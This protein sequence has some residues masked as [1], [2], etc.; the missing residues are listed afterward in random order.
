VARLGGDEFAVLI[1]VPGG[2]PGVGAGVDA[3]AER[4]LDSF[5]RP[6]GDGTNQ[7][8]LQV[9]V[10]VAV[11]GPDGEPDKE[12]LRN[13]DLAMN[14]AR[15]DGAGSL[16]RFTPAVHQRILDRM[17]IEIDLQRALARDELVLYYQPVVE[18]ASGEIKG[19][20]ALIR[21]AHPEKGLV[22]P[23]MFIAVAES[24]GLIVTIG[25]WVLRQACQDLGKWAGPGAPKLRMSVNVSARQLSHPGFEDM[26]VRVLGDSGADPDLITLEITESML[27]HDTAGKADV[28]ER[29]RAMGTRIA[30]D[31]F[32]TGYSSLSS[33]REMPI[34][35]LKIDKSFIDNIASSPEAVSLTQTIIRL[36]NDLGLT[37]IAEGAEKL[38]QVEILRELGCQLVQGY[39]FSKPVPATE[40]QTGLRRGTWGPVRVT[41]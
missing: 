31:D 29:L 25:E 17:R 38:E 34:D 30:L 24:S 22:P 13:A 28:L 15:K 10:G 2:G 39:Y 11:S 16:V 33:I 4:L 12:L 27:I 21:W 19:V 18:L 41:A 35:I 3:A 23:G 1:E 40:L 5:S 8:V 9:I 6:F 7:V 20:E 36:A 26:V 32:G 37:T 14:V